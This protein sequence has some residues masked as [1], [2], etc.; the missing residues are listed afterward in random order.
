M[1]FD[2]AEDM[3]TTIRQG[4]DLYTPQLGL[5][6]FLYSEAGSIAVYHIGT[7]RANV[8]S[9]K[10]KAGSAKYWSELLGPGGAIY[11]DPSCEFYDSAECISNRE[12]CAEYFS[13]EGWNYK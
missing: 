4:K 3:L 5:Y 8:L 10:C 13:M 2:S 7:E 9:D 11:D 12:W 6:V 1:R